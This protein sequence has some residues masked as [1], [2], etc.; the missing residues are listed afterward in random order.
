MRPVGS[1]RKRKSV[2]K[3]P[4]RDRKRSRSLSIDRLPAERPASATPTRSSRA[5]GNGNAQLCFDHSLEIAHAEGRSYGVLKRENDP[6]G[7]VRYVPLGEMFCSMDSVLS[8]DFSMSFESMRLAEIEQSSAID[9]G[10]FDFQPFIDASMRS[11]LIDW[12]AEVC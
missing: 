3:S 8:D 5:L 9:P 12:L 1:D 2:Y 4:P 6:L 7:E 10:L 11:I